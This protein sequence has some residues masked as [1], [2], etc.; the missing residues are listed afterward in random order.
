MSRDFCSEDV[1]KKKSVWDLMQ[2][3]IHKTKQKK[4]NVKKRD[5]TCSGETEQKRHGTFAVCASFK[6]DNMADQYTVNQY[7]DVVVY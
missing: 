2:I 6:N 4:K 3:V 7:C 1:K 5:G